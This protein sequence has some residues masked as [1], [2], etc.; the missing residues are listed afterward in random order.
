M[1][2]GRSICLISRQR[3]VGR[4]NGSSVYLLSIVAFLKAKGYRVHYLSPSPATFGRW[5]AIWLQPE[6]GVFDSIRIRGSVRLGRLLV[7]LDPTVAWRAAIALL[8]RGLR[9]LRPDG[10]PIGRP[11][12]Y[13]IAVPLSSRDKAF[14][15]RYA[16]PLADVVLLDYAFLTEAIAHVGRP[17]APSIVIMHDLFSARAHQFQA[18][19]QVDSVAI[20]DHAQ[21]MRL[22]NMADLVVAIQ[23]DEASVVRAHLPG[24]FVAVA[25]MAVEPAT[26]PHPGD[27]DLVLFVG[28]KTAPNV[29]GLAWFI[30]RVWPEI[31]GA[32]PSARLLV[33]G[34]VAQSY[35]VASPGVT[36]LGQVSRLDDLYRRAGIVISPLRLGSGL[37]VKLIE[38]LSWGK[39]I[40]A[41]TPTA[42][43][44]VELVKDCIALAD[45]P[46]IFAQAVLGLMADEARRRDMAG[47]A[48][49]VAAAHFSAE[50]CYRPITDFIA[51][52]DRP[53]ASGLVRN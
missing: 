38:A 25:P 15:A 33:A 35:A 19:G 45:D 46:G 13:A 10:R 40:V 52:S 4:T 41:T 50:A 27:G 1:Q 24:R 16:P 28:S 48:L 8:D 18:L 2:P 44:V 47:K 11:A 32:R 42:Q 31:R 23:D 53:G 21:E 14:I 7:A 22:L 34:S 51:V 17:D 3:V 9:H 30:E 49:A 43:G 29:D 12:P 39:A 6:M 36:Y 5:P 20:L 37:K 26:E